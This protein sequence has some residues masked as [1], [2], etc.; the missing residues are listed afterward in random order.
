MVAKIVAV[1]LEESFRASS[2]TVLTV[3]NK[4]G[5]K[6]LRSWDFMVSV[7]LIFLLTLL[8]V[9][10]ICIRIHQSL[11]ITLCKVRGEHHF[12]KAPEQPPSKHVRQKQVLLAKCSSWHLWTPNLLA[13][14]P[15]ILTYLI[16]GSYFE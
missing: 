4:E 5:D 13:T 7:I 10:V 2:N 1:L 16:L 12:S 9:E 6:N 15:P 11:S 8:W 14:A 3:S